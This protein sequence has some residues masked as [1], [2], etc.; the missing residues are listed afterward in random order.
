MMIIIPR[1]NWLTHTITHAR[2]RV[3][4]AKIL[5][6]FS[7]NLE[8]LEMTNLRSPKGILARVTQDTL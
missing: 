6:S 7:N 3:S 1:A 8:N 5:M 2:K 4:S